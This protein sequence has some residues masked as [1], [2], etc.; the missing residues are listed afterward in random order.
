MF[1]IIEPMDTNCDFHYYPIGD[2]TYTEVAV[3][4]SFVE[5]TFRND[6]SE[7]TVKQLPADPM[8]EDKGIRSVL[9]FT[10]WK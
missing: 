6:F 3:D 5:S 7:F 4:R 2:K 1:S 9:F 8:M 10:A